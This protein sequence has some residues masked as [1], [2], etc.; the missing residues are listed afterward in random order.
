MRKCKGCAKSHG[1]TQSKVF[2][3]H[4]MTITGTSVM[5]LSNLRTRGRISPYED[6]AIDDT[7]LT[8]V[9]LAALVVLSCSTDLTAMLKLA[10]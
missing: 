10:C 8:E 1:S 2:N 4:F 3:I 6:G 5:A 9:M 7:C